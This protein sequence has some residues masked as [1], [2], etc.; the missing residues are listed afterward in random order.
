MRN[1]IKHTLGPIPWSL[2]KEDGSPTT[3][4]KS[5]LAKALEKVSSDDAEVTND[6]MVIID[7][8]GI[9]QALKNIPDTFGELAKCIFWIS[10]GF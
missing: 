3:T 1:V 2:A 9:L 10:L 7:G 5:K 6:A 4:D 8:M